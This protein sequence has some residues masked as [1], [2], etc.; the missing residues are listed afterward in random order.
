MDFFNELGK[1][2]ELTVLFERENASDRESSWL[3]TDGKHFKAVY[4]KGKKFGT[5]SA[6]CLEA[7]GWLKRGMFDIYIVGGYGTPTGML[8][9][10]ILKIRKIPFILNADGGFIRK[11]SKLKFLIKKHFIKK[12]AYYLSS[13]KETSKC[14]EYY[15]AMSNEISEYPF[16][17]L[18]QNDI[19]DEV[20]SPNEKNAYKERLHIDEDKVIL[21]VGQF[22]Y[23]KG[24]DVLLE[25]CNK[26]SKEY[27]IYIVGGEPTQEYIS[28][29]EKYKLDN[30]HFVGFKSKEELKEYYLA[31]DLFVLPTRE[32]VWGL[33][34]NEAM[35]C[36]L[37]VI[38]TDRCVAGLE[39][40]NENGFIV[41]VDRADI[42]AERIEE[43]M[44]DG[45]LAIQMG[46]ASLE[47]IRPYTIENM[48]EQH[49]SIFNEIVDLA[50]KKVF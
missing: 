45:Q 33:V 16:S 6:L 30:V 19:L 4:L 20:L 48:A 39:L 26:L 36:G 23:R 46:K 13:G 28:L 11:E 34:I 7:S 41:P 29:K 15:G 37:P 49:V 14:L 2:C 8:A 22:I 47:K 9:I 35:A 44:S 27:G 3:S 21:S 1:M 31:S 17:S 40:V 12:A 25:A 50:E 10:E 32:D 5:D 42:L 38:T 43:V 24:F 18:N